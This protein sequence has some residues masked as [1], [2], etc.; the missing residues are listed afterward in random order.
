MTD[1]RGDVIKTGDAENDAP[2]KLGDVCVQALLIDTPQD[3]QSG[4]AEKMRK[5]NMARML[6][7]KMGEPFEEM[8]FVEVPADDISFIQKRIGMTFGTKIAGP[9]CNALEA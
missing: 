6:Q 5:W 9:A 2:A 3:S 8:A 4:F 7:K 1:H